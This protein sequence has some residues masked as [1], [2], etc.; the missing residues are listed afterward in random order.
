MTSTSRTSGLVAPPAVELRGAWRTF[1]GPI[2][3]AAVAD[4]S[5]AVWA[6]QLVAVMGPSGSG[7][8]TLLNLA[9]ALDQPTAGEVLIAGEATAGRGA[10]E[11][12][13]LRR[14]H[15]GF[16][17]QE[18]NLIGSL[19][20]LENVG[21]PRE[22]DGIPVRTARTEARAALA[23]VGLGDVS[24]RYPDELSGGQQQRVAIARALIGGRRLLLADEPTGALDTQTGDDV[25]A[26]LR[27]RCDAGAAAL[28]VTHNN[29]HA[30]WADRVVYLRD[31]RIVDQDTFGTAPLGSRHPGSGG[32]PLSGFGDPA[33]V[34]PGWDD[35]AAGTGR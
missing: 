12:A 9:G 34:E 28:V 25:L 18:L 33:A 8:S 2:Q 30:A 13:R 19:T 17:F 1:P 3:V 7:K 22:L 35:E 21:L 24:G 11:L 29:R 26:L 16:V 5:L 15:L 14:R 10:A 32:L 31:G 27:D 20:A 23:E 4:A 6:G